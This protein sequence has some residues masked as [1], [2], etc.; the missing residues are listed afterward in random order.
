MGKGS[1]SYGTTT[2]QSASGPWAPQA[3]FI[4]QGLSAASDLFSSAPSSTGLT[5]Q[6]SGYLS[7]QISGGNQNAY[8]DDLYKA[9]SNKIKPMVMG[10]FATAGRTGNSPVAKGTVA[11][12]IANAVAPYMFGSA[13]SAQDRQMQAATMAPGLESFI[14]N[15][16]WQQLGNYMNIVGQPYGSQTSSAGQSPISHTG[17]MG[18]RAAGK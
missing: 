13:E 8:I 4:Q 14:T 9:M 12:G 2:Q 10:E 5:G 15:Q 6:A 1:T 7:N 3:P 16:P 11:E 17:P 18:L